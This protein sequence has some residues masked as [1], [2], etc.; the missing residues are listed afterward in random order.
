M[1]AHPDQKFIK[2]MPEGIHSIALLPTLGSGQ[3]M[4]RVVF[5]KLVGYSPLNSST[6]RLPPR[7]FSST[8]LERVLLSRACLFIGLFFKLENL[9]FPTSSFYKYKNG[10]PETAR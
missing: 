8:Y 9:G 6:R 10:G 4:G 5:E 1:R 3:E 2:M 7:L